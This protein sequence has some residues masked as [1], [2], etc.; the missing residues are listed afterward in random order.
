MKPRGKPEA[1][2]RALAAAKLEEHR[3]QQDTSFDEDD[4]VVED[5]EIVI[6]QPQ[7]ITAV[8]LDNHQKSPIQKTVPS[9]NKNSSS[10]TSVLESNSNG[11]VSSN[12]TITS[13]ATTTTIK[14]REFLLGEV[15]PTMTDAEYNNLQDMMIQFCRV[16][17]LSEFSRP[18]AM[19]HPEVRWGML[20][21]IQ[22]ILR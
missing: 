5:A 17:L 7:N 14:K 21:R 20:Y 6:E 3:S 12:T 13:T 16:P 4:E 11:V 22:I 15:A 8:A 19:L 9:R 1:A 18:V 10:A 2:A